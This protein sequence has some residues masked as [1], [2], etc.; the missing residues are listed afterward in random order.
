M[1]VTPS[2]LVRLALERH[3]M[4]WNWTAHFAALVCLALALL[5]HSGLLL[6]AALILLAAGTFDAGLPPMRAGRWQRF[7]R[8]GVEWEKNW[9]A[10][11]WDLGKSARFIIFMVGCVVSVWALWTR[12]LATLGLLVGL[13]LLYWVMLDNLSGGID[14]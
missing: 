5:L 11:S 8:R 12:E 13:G 1:T 7:V 10:A 3:R 14:P 2:D 9:A 6:A 4:E